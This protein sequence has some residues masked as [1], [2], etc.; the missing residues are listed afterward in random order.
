MIRTAFDLRFK[1]FETQCELDLDSNCLKILASM[2]ENV[3]ELLDFV[4]VAMKNG[5]G[6][7]KMNPTLLRIAAELCDYL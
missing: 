2:F 4:F 5:Q 3:E 1:A 7:M 6:H